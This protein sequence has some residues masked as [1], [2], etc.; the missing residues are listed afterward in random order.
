KLQSIRTLTEGLKCEGYFFP[1][2]ARLA[3]EQHNLLP[4]ARTYYFKSIVDLTEWPVGEHPLDLADGI[5]FVGNTAQFAILLAMYFGAN[6]IILLGMD[7]DF[8][9]HRSIN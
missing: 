4:P 2:D 7:H 9:T 6:P 5:P 8:L 3:I 1:F